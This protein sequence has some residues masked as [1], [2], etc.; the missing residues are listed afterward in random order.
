MA[1]TPPRATGSTWLWRTMLL[2]AGLL[3]MGLALSSQQRPAGETQN[4]PLVVVSATDAKPVH[5][6]ASVGSTDWTA[7]NPRM[8]APFRLGDRIRARP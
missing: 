3:A 1:E 4:P 6:E 5:T 2:V 8:E 7:T